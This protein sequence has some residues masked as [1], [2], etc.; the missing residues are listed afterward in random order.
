[1]QR[2][3][4]CIIPAPSFVSKPVSHLYKDSTSQPVV[5]KFS[6]IVSSV[7]HYQRSFESLNTSLSYLSL[8]LAL[9]ENADKRERNMMFSEKSVSLCPH[10]I[11]SIKMLS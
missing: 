1:M 3:S 4:T 6:L 5:T 2:Y 9:S 8:L 11:I 7:E 10:H